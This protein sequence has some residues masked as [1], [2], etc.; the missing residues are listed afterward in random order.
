MKLG[1][2]A[3]RL[4]FRFITESGNEDVDVTGGYVGDLLSDVMA[5]AEEGNIWITL[6]THVNIVAVATLK[7]IS[8]VVI[9]N[10]RRPG[11]DTINKA[12][13]ERIPLMI[14]DLSAFE[15]AGRLY[16]MLNAE[17]LQD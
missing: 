1:L 8:G 13:T 2:I 3:E 16:R 9:V 7:G 15:A 4:G 12:D 6:Q 14:T 17:N 5:N 11:T 10:G